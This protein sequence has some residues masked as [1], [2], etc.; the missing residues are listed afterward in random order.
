MISTPEEAVSARV[1]YGSLNK[2]AEATGTPRIT[3]QRLHRVATGEGLVEPPKVGGQFITYPCSLEHFAKLYDEN[4]KSIRA[5]TRI[6]GISNR[7]VDRMLDE[8]IAAGCFK[9]LPPTSKTK[10]VE[11]KMVKLTE[12]RVAPPKVRQFS[13][14]APGQVNRY[15]FTCAQ[16]DTKIHSKLWENILA[17]AEHYGAEV[18]VSRFTYMK[19]GLGARGDKAQFT[20]KGETLYG[21]D[22]LTWDPALDPYI[23]DERAKV[24]TGL[25]WC[26]EQNILP[27]KA[28]PLSG[29]ETYT[30]RSSGI[31]PHPKIAMESIA[32]SR[33]EPTKFNYTTGCVTLRNYIQRT[34]GL[35]A[36]FHHVYGALLV[37]VDSDGD[38]FCRQLKGSNDGTI[39]DLDLR[40]KNGI[41]E[42]GDWVEA[43]LWGDIHVA[44]LDTVVSDVAFGP[45]GILDTLKPKYQFMG[46]VLDF[47][48]RS[49]HDIKDPHIVFH[50]HVWGLE[51]V[52]QELVDT[53]LFL[54]DTRRPWCQT[55]VVDSN[56]H[57]HLGRWLKEQ[58][59]LKD[60]VNAEFW[61]RMQTR[62]LELIRQTGKPDCNYLRE[63][64]QVVGAD[65]DS[66]RFLDEDESFV[67]C[68]RD[69]EGGIEC[70]LHGDLGPNGSRGSS[71]NLSRSGRK[72]N[73]G[74]SHSAN[75]VDGIYQAG[76]FSILNPDYTRGPS[77]WSHSYIVTYGNGARF[78]GTVTNGKW[79]ADPALHKTATS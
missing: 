24:A 6:L 18:F 66:I 77:S 42:K 23:L 45:G 16:N 4:G 32:S 20:K 48:S 17:L 73:I 72:A 59:G 33:H 56:H 13:R 47:R 54:A 9:T 40:V 57:N 71:R 58:N 41:V 11:E 44:N 28:R 12:G 19:S 21:G 55:V 61:M 70:G 78:V 1:Q 29:F 34:A 39:H 69:G 37:E 27:T 60:P 7:V 26:G 35:K 64:L 14:P 46:D 74:H 50:K 31:F 49:H 15:I 52:E 53:G 8:A 36:E 38:W 79:R 5:M 43:V 62:V 22:S 63:G 76:T 68:S 65:T 10:T 51:D 75:I 30:G 67:I 3:L 2:A 25:E